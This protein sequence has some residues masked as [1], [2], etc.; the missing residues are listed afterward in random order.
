MSIL[1][2]AENSNKE[3]KS[4]TLNSISAASKINDDIHLVVIGNQCEEVAKK[5]ALIEKVK[6]VIHIDDPQYENIIAESIA[7][8]IVSLSDKYTHILAPAS[9]FGKNLMP[10]VA[11]LLDLSQISDVIRI[12]N[13]DTFVRPIYAG[14][15]FA[16]VQSTE[17]KKIITIRPTS[18]DPAYSEGGS[19]NIEKVSFN[20][21]QSLVEF[22]G[23][24]ESKSERPEL[25]TA[26]IV[27]SGGRGL[28]SAENF[29]MI[30]EIAD[31][32]NAAVGASRAAVDAGYVSNDYQVGQTGKV[33]VPDLYIAI[34]ISGAI[35]HLAGMKE[36]K[37]IVAINKDE[38]APIFNV[39]DYGLHADLF[40]VLPQL[41]AELDKLN[42]IQK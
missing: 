31:K 2:V 8:I 11:A 36:S 25:G 28:Q 38:E 24:E 9:T 6:K 26:R 19:A 12:E 16:T 33:V 30:I 20:A 10:R 42:T 17:N 22:I 18:F 14:N 34:G 23:R 13:E 27:I 4:S 40:E 39:A 7:P 29:S 32:L 1:V 35:Q 21:D 15:A 37:V 41:S 5:A 3:I